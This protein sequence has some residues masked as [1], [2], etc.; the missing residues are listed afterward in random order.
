MKLY[1]DIDGV[2]LGKTT[3]GKLSLAHQTVEFL[4]FALA[5]FDCYWLTTHCKGDAS[6]ALDYLAPY[7]SQEV[8]TLL[9]QIKATHFRTFK[10]EAL[11]GDFIWI[12]DAPTAYEIQVLDEN[13]WLDRWF[14][15]DT[16]KDLGG[17]VALIPLLK[18]CLSRS[19]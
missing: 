18:A 15:I 5:H 1:I 12:D 6:T 11:N 8:M 10:T 2:L 13:D 14:E 16:R 9:S 4:Q 19:N 7:S 17:L 3:D